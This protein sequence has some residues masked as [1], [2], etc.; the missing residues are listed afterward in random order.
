M[1]A[2]NAITNHDEHLF[3]TWSEKSAY[4]LGYLEADGQIKYDGPA[5]RVYFQCSGK[6]REFL[7]MLKKITAFTGTLGSSDNWASGKKYE[8][9]RFTVSS[10]SW[11]NSPLLK[12]LRTGNIANIPEE[13]IHHYIRGYFDGDGSIFWSKQAQHKRSN[14]VFNNISLAQDFALLLRKITKAKLTIHKKTS[15]DH[16]WYFQLGNKATERLII[17]MYRDANMY[18]KRKHRLASEFL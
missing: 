2:P 4:L 10:R 14:F 8:K 17:Y 7:Q 3:D 15:S 11:R 13:L 16:C 9:V 1:E 6:D 18:M 12:E 5:V